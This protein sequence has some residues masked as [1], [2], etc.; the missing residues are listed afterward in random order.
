MRRAQRLFGML[1]LLA[2]A[3]LFTADSPTHAQIG[4]GGGGGIGGIGGG[5]GGGIGGGGGGTTG[6]TAGTSG[7]NGVVIDADGVL[8]L[9]HF[10][11]PTGA[12]AASGLPRPRPT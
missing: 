1:L 12:D 4:G 7:A 10:P 6:S 9:Q 2:L 11:D 3:A 8:R 5:G